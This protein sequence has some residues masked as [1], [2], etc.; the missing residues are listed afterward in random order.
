MGFEREAAI[1]TLVFVAAPALILVLIGV[2]S[3]YINTLILLL[4]AFLLFGD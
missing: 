4:S 1:K 2:P 3:D